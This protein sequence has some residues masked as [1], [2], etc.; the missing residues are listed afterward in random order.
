MTQANFTINSRKGKHLDYAER[1]YIEILLKE[2]Y[3]N[4]RI[5][6]TLGRCPQT[7]HNEVHRGTVSQL[8][9]RQ[10][11]QGKVYD[12]Y[13]QVYSADA[14]QADYDTQ[15]LQCG[16][17]PKWVAARCFIEWADHQMLH[18]RWSPDIVVKYARKQRLF[19]DAL[20][21]CTTTLYQWIDRGIMRTKNIDLLEKLSRSTKVKDHSK[22]L[23]KRILGPS[24][25]QR[26]AHINDRVAFGHWEIDTVIGQKQKS[27]PV[28]LTLVERSTRFELVMKLAG[29][30]AASVT[31]AFT[32]LKARAGEEFPRLFKSITADN[33]SEFAELYELL[34]GTVAVYFAHPYASWERGSSENQHKLIRRYLPKGTSL[35]EVTETDCLRIQQWMNDYP[36]KILDYDTP[37][38]RF[39]RAFHQER[40]RA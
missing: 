34:K 35:K 22:R 36:R 25:D 33:G 31:Q 3:S 24:I 28:L 11:Q 1:C 23:N 30:D 32:A 39:V 38:D 4:R 29:K 17:Q 14:G 10:K 37:H 7:I 9:Q 5:A 20:I 13:H 12:Y 18:E 6:R 26:P 16:R 2:G 19:D 21:P 15:R 8:K 27:E 40:Q